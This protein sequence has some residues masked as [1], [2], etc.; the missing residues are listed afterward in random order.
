[1]AVYRRAGRDSVEETKRVDKTMSGDTVSYSRSRSLALR[2]QSKSKIIS[3]V[4]FRE[5]FGPEMSSGRSRSFRICCTFRPPRTVTRLRLVNTIQ[6]FRALS[7]KLF[8]QWDGLQ[9]SDKITRFANVAP[10]V[11]RGCHLRSIK[12]HALLL[13]G[14]IAVM[15]RG[16]Y[17]TIY[18]TVLAAGAPASGST[19]LAE[20]IEFG[21]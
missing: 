16:N 9:L 10:S 21:D 17:V 8:S 11:R 12:T 3:A 4:P 1:M 7:R 13:S 15:T 2:K 14:R 5:E 6:L 19:S 18:L 20:V